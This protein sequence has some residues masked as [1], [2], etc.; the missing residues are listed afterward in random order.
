MRG[1][2]GRWTGIG[3]TLARRVLV[4]GGAGF[5]G[6]QLVRR[7][8]EAGDDVAVYVRRSGA[9]TRIDDLLEWV[10]V[11]RGSDPLPS[12]STIYHLAASGLRPGDDPA[13][14]AA[15]NLL[16]TE[17][18]LEHA[19]SCQA[20]RFVQCGSCFEYGPGERF[21]E[22]AP[23]RPISAYGASKAAASL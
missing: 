10:E 13:D 9:L 8:L 5:V 14:V 21:P 22:D 17:R 18:L 7:L 20:E 11:V 2:P 23:L 16:L 3:H 4:T 15:S 6:S 1:S 19:G 12:V